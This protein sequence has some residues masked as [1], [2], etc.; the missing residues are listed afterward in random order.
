MRTIKNLLLSA[1]L[2]FA[3][4]L[5]SYAQLSLT[6]GVSQV[7]PSSGMAGDTVAVQATVV[8]LFGTRVY[9]G[10]QVASCTPIQLLNLGGVLGLS[11]ITQCTVPAGTAGSTVDVTIQNLVTLEVGASGSFTYATPPPPGVS[12]LSPTSGYV[13]STVQVTVPS[14]PQTGTEVLFG[15]TAAVCSPFAQNG[16]AYTA[17][18]TVPAGSGNVTVALKKDTQT[19]AGLSFSYLTVPPA[20]TALTPLTGFTGTPVS[21]SVGVMPQ[22]G[23]QV[24][25]GTYVASCTAFVPDL[26]GFTAVCAAPTGPVPGPV[27]VVLTNNS[28]D[29]TSSFNFT[30]LAPPSITSI[31]PASGYA[32]ASVTVQ[33][34]SLPQAGTVV[35]FGANAAVCTSFTGSGSNYTATCTVPASTVTGNVMVQLVNGLQVGVGA[36][37]NYL[38]PPDVISLTPASGYAATAVTVAVATMPAAGTTVKFDTTA[39]VCTPFTSNGPGYAAVCNA[40][41]GL[42]GSVNVSL[43]NNGQSGLSQVYQYLVPVTPVAVTGLN[44]TSGY[45]G[46][47]VTV[48][49]GTLPTPDSQVYF[50]T[51]LAVCTPFVAGGGGFE[52]TCVVPAGSGTT[53]VTLKNSAGSGTGVNFTYTVAPTPPAISGVVPLSGFA[54]DTI[55]ITAAAALPAGTKVMFGSTEAV[56]TIS[57]ATATCTVPDGAALGSS[58]SVTLQTP[59]GVSAGVTF[60]Y[61]ALPAAILIPNNGRPGDIISVSAA[62]P[63]PA[64]TKVMFGTYEA[65]CAAFT[66]QGGAGVITTCTVPSGP[67]LGSSVNVTLQTSQGSGAGAPFLYNPLP[68]VTALSKTTGSAG[69]NVVVSTDSALPSGAKIVFDSYE[70]SCAAGSPNGSGGFDSSCT[71]PLGP[72]SGSN[73]QVKVQTADGVGVGLGFGYA[74]VVAVTPQITSIAPVSGWTGTQVTINGD[75]L[76][77]AA[78]TFG[79]KTAVCTEVSS[80]QLNCAAP[81]PDAA[82]AVN[83]VAATV[84]GVATSP[85]QF[86]YDLSQAPLPFAPNITRNV[87][88]GETLVLNLADGSTNGP[89]TSANIIE[90]VPSSEGTLALQ[91]LIMTFNPADTFEGTIDL[92]Y[93]LTNALGAVSQQ[94]TITLNVLNV[95]PDP[96]Q[97]AETKAMMSAQLTSVKRY[98]RTQM[99]NFNS[100]LSQI[101]GD[102]ELRNNFN[103]SF[104]VKEVQNSLYA[105]GTNSIDQLMAQNPQSAGNSVSVSDVVNTFAPMPM[106]E[107][108]RDFAVW[109]NGAVHIGSEKTAGDLDYTTVGV[110]A[111]IDKAITEDWVAGVGI[112]Y[113]R[114]KTD[115]G[116]HSDLTGGAYSLVTYSSYKL[117]ANTYLEGL[118]GYSFVHMDADRSTTNGTASG[119]RDADQ[120]FGS[121]GAAYAYKDGG[122]QLSPFARLEAAWTGLKS[123]TESG[124]GNMNLKYGHSNVKMFALATGIDNS[125]RFEKTWGDIVPS[126]GVEYTHNFDE[127]STMRV[128]YAD[129]GATPYGFSGQVFSRDNISF[130]ASVD[131][132]LKSDWSF[133]GG[134]KFTRGDNATDNRFSLQGRYYF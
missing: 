84:N 131:F 9:F 25:F 105:F 2:L 4:T 127:N 31:T 54:G 108:P 38:L 13:G 134:Y 81:A 61:S 7:Y 112:G 110:S 70:A 78:V 65:V 66:P 126:V 21:I 20:V 96:T 56:C 114:D 71:V 18:C 64:G 27:N 86:T 101:R 111:G 125:Y 98:I 53:S 28:Q 40:P 73:V 113:T 45:E 115:V 103:V 88:H 43:E 97:D 120:V 67:A 77:G 10:T 19:G 119:T 76:S 36:N 93:T 57:G 60:T 23:T 5:P 106:Q 17:T 69:D 12:S 6:V 80:S 14:Q 50:G 92:H 24:K 63:V 95:R 15:S 94:G 16:S 90:T 30:Y 107:D 89:I 58:V 8:P 32:G 99:D 123:Y 22:S 68:A 48:T 35:Q 118:L 133:F 44:P 79:T 29:G 49:A 85:T 102:S 128:G 75:N 74:A 104:G 121:L 91:Q 116:S 100:R 82:G 26:N 129:T 52:S 47:T 1:L 124:A 55:T 132:I 46:Q 72:A 41:D 34:P 11:P 130:D 39:A 117:G 59:A 3:V 37:F 83:V 122:W 42:S 33:V 87:Y 62:G 51:T 109:T